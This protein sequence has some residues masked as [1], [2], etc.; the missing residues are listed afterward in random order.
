MW[1]MRAEHRVTRG[2]GLLEP[3]LARL[4]AR[5]ADRLIPSDLRGGR[6]LDI[7]CGTRPYFL[8]QT[9]FGEKFA[10][11]RHAPP[12]PQDHIAWHTLDI[13]EAT[14]LPFADQFFSVVTM[15]AVVEHLDPDK[16]GRVFR[17]ARRTLRPGGVLFLTTPAPWSGP[18]LRA[19]ARVGFVSRE[20]VDEHRYAGRRVALGMA[21]AESG[22]DMDHI[23]SGYFEC[24]LNMWAVARR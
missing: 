22:F 12:G 13:E 11:D 23:R 3:F 1:T 24:G 16:V 7:G 15:L 9:S 5:Q 8:S 18:L 2:N 20:E 21:L 6:I 17:E 4:R 10:I 14:A 19:M